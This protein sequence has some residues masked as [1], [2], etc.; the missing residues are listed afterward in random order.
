MA[1]MANQSHG[2]AGCKGAKEVS[3][4]LLKIF[5]TGLKH[6]FRGNKRIAADDATE[7]HPQKRVRSKDVS[8]MK[9]SSISETSISCYALALFVNVLAYFQ[10]M[11]GLINVL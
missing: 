4:F 10:D 5:R 3:Y 2:N 7:V 6:D 9:A 11:E 8:T 1:R